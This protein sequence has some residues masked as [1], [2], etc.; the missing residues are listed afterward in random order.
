MGLFDV[1]SKYVDALAY[2]YELY[3]YKKH[4]NGMPL[5]VFYE[6]TSIS[7]WKCGGTESQ[8][9]AGLLLSGTGED[10]RKKEER[11]SE[12]EAKFGLDVSKII[13]EILKAKS[14]TKD[15]WRARKVHYLMYIENS[16]PSERLVA[17]AHELSYLQSLR[18]HVQLHGES[19]WESDHVTKEQVLWF[20]HTFADIL[21]DK[22]SNEVGTSFLNELSLIENNKR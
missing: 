16:S 9:I 7:V 8:A 13:S 11:L 20:Y 1:S 2:A 14:V 19:I 17:G 3:K 12:I 18:E 4:D 6:N 10:Q 21:I 5:L 22:G 15:S